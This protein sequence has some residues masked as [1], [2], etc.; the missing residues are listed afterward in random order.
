MAVLGVGGR[1]ELRREAASPCVIT[2]E[3]I[4]LGSS[5]FDFAVRAIGLVIA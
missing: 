5:T 3:D 4:N 2:P 1:L